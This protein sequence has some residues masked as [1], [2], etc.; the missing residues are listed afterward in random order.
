MQAVR[1]ARPASVEEAVSLLVTGEGRARVLAGGTD[2]I[3][4]ARERRID[5]DTVVDVKHIPELQAISF[6]LADGLTIG[7]ATPLYRVYGDPSVR[8]HFAALA[9][10]TRVIGGT[11][12]Q[13][14]ASLGGNLANASPAADGIAAMIALGAVAR[15]VGP[16][17]G[18]ELPV[19]EFCTGPGRNALEAG[20]FVRA[21]HFPAP[22]AGSGSA[23]ERFIPRNEMDIAVVN[24]GASITLEGDVVTG[25]R[26][27]LGAVAP[28]PLALTD[29]AAALVGRRLDD[30]AVEEAARAAS[31]AARPISDM[32]GSQAQ[33]TH[34]AGVLTGRVLR[35]AAARA[36]REEVTE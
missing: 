21:L 27:A 6:D 11:A 31:A 17:G 1:Y 26:L 5:V 14:R 30:A 7:A 28:T 22:P 10:A 18:R 32:R 12:I 2:L 34:L 29:A 4:Q 15:V 9:E 33:R 19:A 8:T 36:R 35:A 23:W 3:V 13:G 20:E 25:A 24:A 16:G